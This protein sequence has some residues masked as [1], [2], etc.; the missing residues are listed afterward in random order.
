MVDMRRACARIRPS[1]ASGRDASGWEEGFPLSRPDGGRWHGPRNGSDDPGRRCLFS[2]REALLAEEPPI[3][4]GCAAPPAWP[5]PFLL[6][7]TPDAGFVPL[8][9]VDR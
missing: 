2:P 4:E 8:T 9:A 6:S 1:Q 3:G 5:S 7:A